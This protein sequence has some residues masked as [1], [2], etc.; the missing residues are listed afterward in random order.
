MVVDHQVK[1]LALHCSGPA[2]LPHLIHFFIDVSLDAVLLFLTH[3]LSSAFFSHQNTQTI[4]F[5]LPQDYLK[6]QSTVRFKH[7]QKTHTLMFS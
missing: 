6:K 5:F 4:F 2:V 7:D 1:H 3:S